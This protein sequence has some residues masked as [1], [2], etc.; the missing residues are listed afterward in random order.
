[1]GYFGCGQETIDMVQRN[2][3]QNA[4]TS[5]FP[6]LVLKL[7]KKQCVVGRKRKNKV[8]VWNNSAYN[9]PDKN[10]GGWVSV[11]VLLLQYVKTKNK[12]LSQCVTEKIK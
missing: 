3:K 12:K 8:D 7:N 10:Q 11:T 5:S 6:R 4:S 1:M 9:L 2:N